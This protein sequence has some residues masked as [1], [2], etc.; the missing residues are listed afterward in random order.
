M[1]KKQRFFLVIFLFV[2]CATYS[3]GQQQ[4]FVWSTV[5]GSNARVIPMSSVKAEVMRLYD[6]HSWMRFEAD[7][8]G[9]YFMDRTEH[10][11]VI[12]GLYNFS[13]DDPRADR[14]Q[15]QHRRQIITWYDTHRNFVYMRDIGGGMLIV[16]F[17]TSDTVMEVTFGNI[18]Y[19]GWYSTRAGDNRRIFEGN[20]DW[21]LA[22][23]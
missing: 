16:S 2:F 15:Q 12:V 21:L 3:F 8:Y 22:N 14:V 18:S 17:V 7:I 9:E 10:R 13:L 5:S 4:I 20:I 11:N 23:R 6:L 19:Q 1:R